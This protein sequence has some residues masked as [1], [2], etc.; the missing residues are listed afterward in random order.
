MIFP[1]RYEEDMQ[2]LKASVIAKVKD[3]ESKEIEDEFA[4]S[5]SHLEHAARTAMVAMLQVTPQFSCTSMLLLMEEASFG[6]FS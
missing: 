5:C 2:Y 3:M 6:L 4:Q 1:G